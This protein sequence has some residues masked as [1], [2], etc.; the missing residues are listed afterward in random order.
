MSLNTQNSSKGGGEEQR[1][2]AEGETH[3]PEKRRGGRWSTDGDTDKGKNSPTL[4]EPELSQP[5]LLC[6][7]DSMRRSALL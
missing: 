7:D 1:W 6:S 2:C 5:H 3:A 4:A